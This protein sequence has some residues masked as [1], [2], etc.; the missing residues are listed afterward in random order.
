MCQLQS[1]D[2]I[3][4]DTEGLT[5]SLTASRQQT[6]KIRNGLLVQMQLTGIGSAIFSDGGGFAPNELGAARAETDIS[7]K[8]QLV[9]AAIERAITTLHGLNAKRVANSKG[10]DVPRPKQRTQ[11]IAEA[12]IQTQSRAL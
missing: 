5:M 8:R 9:G 12:Q 3:V 11:V 7:A 4:V 2:Q 1:D 6:L 10:S